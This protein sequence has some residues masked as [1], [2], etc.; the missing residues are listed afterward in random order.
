MHCRESLNTPRAAC[1]HSR[2]N[3]PQDSINIYLYIL[4]LNGPRSRYPHP[5]AQITN[6]VTGIEIDKYRYGFV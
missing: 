6:S 1:G 2:L 4:R 3:Y 5:G